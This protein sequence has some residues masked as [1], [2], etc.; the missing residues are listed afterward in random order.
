MNQEDWRARLV[1][2]LRERR[3][4]ELATALAEAS[5]DRWGQPVEGRDLGG[6]DLRGARLH[7]LKLE[8]P[9]LAGADWSEAVLEK[10]GFYGAH[11]KGF[12]LERAVLR[13]VIDGDFEG[14]CFREADLRR[15]ALSGSF[16][17]ANFRG[18]RLDEASFGL[19]SAFDEA[20]FSGATMRGPEPQ[21]CLGMQGEAVSFR[22]AKFVGADLTRFDIKIADFDE[23][24]F[25]D[26]VLENAVF[27]GGEENSISSFRGARLVRVRA[28]GA[29]FLGAD[30]RDA[31]T[32]GADFGEG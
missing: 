32:T 13:G 24:D 2:L 26:A 27:S 3:Y 23:A 31:D 7:G 21:S 6:I 18:A 20:D 10:V 29:S 19:A 8:E 28:R 9:A 30:L 14:A 4:E 17:G 1:L 15:C 16:R 22:R 5:S 25:T 11:A 12:R